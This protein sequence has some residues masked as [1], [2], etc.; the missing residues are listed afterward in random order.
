MRQGTE[1]LCKEHFL[2]SLW[3]NKTCSHGIISPLTGINQYYSTMLEIPLIYLLSLR[4]GKTHRYFQYLVNIFSELVPNYFILWMEHS[5]CILAL[6]ISLLCF[7]STHVNCPLTRKDGVF[8]KTPSGK[9]SCIVKPLSAIT[10]S[11]GCKC[12]R[13]PVSC[14]CMRHSHP[15]GHWWR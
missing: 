12:W 6:E 3:R 8:R 7:N 15:I 13:S 5:I 9:M 10:I 4:I 1:L 14:Y 2:C 11:P